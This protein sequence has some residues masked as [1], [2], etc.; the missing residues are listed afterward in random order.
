MTRTRTKP[1][2]TKGKRRTQAERRSE[3]SAGLVKA[4]IKVVCSDGVSATTFETIAR[5]GNYSRALVTKRFGSKQGLIEAVIAYLRAR[6]EALAI[7]KRVDEM[8]GF[9]ALLAYIEIYMHHLATD[10]N[11]QA[12]YRLFSS[13]LADKSP[14]QQLFV[15]EH[16]RFHNRLAEIVRRGQ[17]EGHIRADLD[18]DSAAFTAGGLVFST[19]MSLLL[20]PAM[21]ISPIQRSWAE[22]LRAAFATPVPLGRQHR[23]RRPK[24]TRTA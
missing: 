8:P 11:G 5:R 24:K 18:P 1:S 4:A 6:P 2:N 20:N 13:A 21:D 7:E 22:T 10:E 12:Y 19:A 16:Q 17:K 15:A 14:L 23:A 3:S 9:E